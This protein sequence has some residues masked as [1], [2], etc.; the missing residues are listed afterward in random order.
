MLITAIKV[1]I[2]YIIWPTPRGCL[3]PSNN[4]SLRVSYNE[5]SGSS[6]SWAIKHNL[7]KPR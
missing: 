4:R 1:I 6:N 3:V 2:C 5:Q 7:V